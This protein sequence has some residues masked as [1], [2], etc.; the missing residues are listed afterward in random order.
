MM[1]TA[2]LTARNENRNKEIKLNCL[3]QTLR[4]HNLIGRLQPEAPLMWKIH[5]EYDA[6]H[7]ILQLQHRIGRDWAGEQTGN[8]V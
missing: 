8:T 5:L 6:L 3:I 2:I 4:E 1:P 7:R